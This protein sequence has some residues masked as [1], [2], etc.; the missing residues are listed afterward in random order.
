MLF[1]DLDL[2]KNYTY[3]NYYECDFAERVELINGEI[4]RLSPA[5][6][7]QH[8]EIVVD[9]ITVLR[10]FLQNKP[11]K[12]F[13]TPLIDTIKPLQF[14]NIFYCIIR[15]FNFHLYYAYSIIYKNTI[16]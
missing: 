13:V 9:I 7:R 10:N 11:C 6:N 3:A 8:Q 4:S 5:T 12:V 14:P 2:S 16:I 15:V 1:S